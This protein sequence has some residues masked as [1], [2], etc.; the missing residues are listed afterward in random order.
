MIKKEYFILF[1]VV[2]VLNVHSQDSF[3]FDAKSYFNEGYFS[4]SHSLFLESFYNHNGDQDEVLYFIAASSKELKYTDAEYWYSVL[5]EKH[6][7]S[8]LFVE[9]CYCV[10][11]NSK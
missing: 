1:F 5:I 2:F 8:P 7:T 9:L 10:I 6:S 3:S 4:I 11:A